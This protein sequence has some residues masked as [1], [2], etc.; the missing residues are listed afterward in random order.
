MWHMEFPRIPYTRRTNR[1]FNYQPVYFDPEMDDLQHRVNMA[2]GETS[3]EQTYGDN[4]RR[5]FRS[6][7]NAHANRYNHELRKSK[8]RMWLLVLFFGVLAWYVF[9]SDLIFRIFEAFING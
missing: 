8:I 5:G 6:F 4:I 2:R 7:G 1:R 3:N 9:Q